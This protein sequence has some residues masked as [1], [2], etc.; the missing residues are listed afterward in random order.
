V[1]IAMPG[2]LLLGE[3]DFSFTLAL[4]KLLRTISQSGEKSTTSVLQ[5]KVY[6]TSYDSEGEVA[7]K[8]PGS[9]N[10]LN[11]IS[12]DDF[13]RGVYH[14]V[15]ATKPLL[16]SLQMCREEASSIDHIIFNFPHLGIEDCKVCSMGI[17]PTL[18]HPIHV[19]IH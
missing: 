6:S 11:M 17:F 1:A 12:K 3:G 13:V 4:L 7:S 19:T 15:D 18:I 14:G 16:P 5:W 2:I 8:Y 10:T 9:K